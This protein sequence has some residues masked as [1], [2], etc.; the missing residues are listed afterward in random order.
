M[1]YSIVRSNPIRFPMPS[2]GYYLEVVTS[3]DDGDYPKT[4][5]YSVKSLEAAVADYNSL[6]DLDQLKKDDPDKFLDVIGQTS[7]GMPR[8]LDY[9]KIVEVFV[10][11]DSVLYESFIHVVSK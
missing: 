9:F 1:K 2:P 6:R 3:E 7:S 5:R 4:E 10:G 8:D 11:S